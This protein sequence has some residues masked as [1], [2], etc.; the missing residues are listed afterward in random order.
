MAEGKSRSFRTG[1]WLLSH[2]VDERKHYGLFGDIEEIYD[3]RLKEKGQRKADIWLWLQVTKTI[4]ASLKNS[5]YWN[6]VMFANYFKITFRNFKRHKAYSLTNVIGLAVGMTCCICILVFVRHELSYDRYHADADNIFRLVMNGE[7][8]DRPFDVALSSGPIGPIMAEQFPEVDKVARFQHRDR[9][10]INFRGKQFFEEGVFFADET[11]FDVFTFPLSKGNPETALK[12]PFTAVITQETAERYFGDANPVGEALRFNRQE[13]YLITG[14]MKNVPENSHFAFDFLLSFKTLLTLRRHQIESWT[15]FTNYTYLRLKDGADP[16]ELAK[17]VFPLNTMHMGFDP[18][19]LGWDLFFT[20]QPLPSIHL[21]SNLQNEMKGNGDISYVYFFSSIAALI[22]I[23]ACIN[24][25]NLA[26]AR[27]SNRAKEVGLRKVLGA[28]R[29]KLIK[30]FLGESL[31]YSFLSLLVALILSGLVLPIL[32]SFLGHNIGTR[33]GGIAALIPG[34]FGIALFVGL[35]A[36]LYPAIIL[37][38][39]QPANAIKGGFHLAWQ[40]KPLRSVL[41]AAQLAIST[42]LIIGTGIIFEQVTFMKNKKLGFEKEHVMVVRISGDSVLPSIPS[43][44]REI[45]NL[46]GVLNVTASSHIPGWDGLAAAH[47]PEGFPN[48]ESQTMRIIR[49]DQDFLDTFGIRLAAGRNFS[50]EFPAD[51]QESVLINETAASKFGW[52][53]PL[54]KKIQEIYG[55]KQTK[56]VIGVLEDFHM[57]SLHNMIEPMYITASHPGINVLCIRISHAN[58]AGLLDTIRSTWRDI[59]SGAPFDYFF[60]DESFDRTYRAEERLSRLFSTFSL[61]AIFIACLGLFGM[62]CYSAERRTKEIGIRKVLGASSSGI[63]YLF[64]QELL[65]IFLIA[66]IVSWPIVYMA[67]NKWLHNFAYRTE[68]GIEIFVLSALLTLAIALGTIG[69][70][71]IKSSLADPADTLRY[72]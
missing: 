41:V 54:G 33:I 35:A 53:D 59:A 51:P 44:K 3:F 57:T 13:E 20:L 63:V 36:G 17:K 30:Q 27:S 23:L 42:S 2:L 1:I 7:F 62:A 9:T 32:S 28:V 58:V 24:F 49:V 46:H 64:S 61:L 4:L 71:A 26:S 65:R 8:S 68:I 67:S 60:L 70:Q 56:T 34:F 14:V 47:L 21:Y 18:K 15:Q 40:G 69:Y 6:W 72:E 55:T 38:R 66:N 39:F 11:V 19:D 50:L 31:I 52:T 48:E 5:L 25:M 16:E 37:A 22:L 29:S 12:D 45:K 10:P 43:I